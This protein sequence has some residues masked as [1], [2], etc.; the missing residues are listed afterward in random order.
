[1]GF[2]S[3]KPFNCRYDIHGPSQGDSYSLVETGR[4]E[5]DRREGGVEQG[6]RRERERVRER[7]KEGGRAG[8]RRE[9]EH[10]SEVEGCGWTGLLRC[11]AANEKDEGKKGAG[12]EDGTGAIA[13]LL[14]L[15]LVWSSSKY[16]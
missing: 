11:L 13:W 7:G 6:S 12:E 3:L 1:M 10:G 4:G 15:R 2:K 8:E 5:R 9:I 14:S 16:D